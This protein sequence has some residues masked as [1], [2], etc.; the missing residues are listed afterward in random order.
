MSHDV[1]KGVEQFAS[2]SAHAAACA[3]AAFWRRRAQ[4]PI[5][6]APSPVPASSDSLSLWVDNLQG[7]MAPFVDDE[8]QLQLFAAN[9]I[10]DSNEAL[11]AMTL[12]SF[13]KV[14]QLVTQLSSGKGNA[15]VE[16]LRE[17]REAKGALPTSGPWAETLDLFCEA[18]HK[19]NPPMRVFSKKTC[20]R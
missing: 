2:T 4:F 19:S 1:A 6:I 16:H 14:G 7:L 8:A 11:A 13:D 5:D 17:L 12:S 15:S 10:A 3:H 9:F 20:F 18:G